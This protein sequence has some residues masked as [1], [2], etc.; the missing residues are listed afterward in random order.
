MT[1]S[2]AIDTST[3]GWAGLTAEL[4]HWH[5][6]GRTATLWW[7]DDDAVEDTLALRRLI[8]VA[9]APIA[10][11]VIPAALQD[12][13]APCL[14]ESGERGRIS[15]LQHGFAHRNHEPA[16]QKKA[17]LGAARPIATVL[18]ELTEG[19]RLLRRAFGGRSLPVLTPPW[20][21]ISA[22]LITHLP[23][24]GFRGLTTYLPRRS[25]WPANTLLQVN[26]HVD[27]I[28]WHGGRGFIG[29]EQ[30]LDLLTRHL[31]ARRKAVADSAEPTGILTHHLVQ[32]DAS[33]DF[34]DRLQDWLSAYPV[35]RWLT[36][37]EVFAVAMDRMGE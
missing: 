8:T 15:V 30:C 25:A 32:D 20:N 11:A 13:L 5:D 24:A 26:T 6:S 33:W 23:Q 31:Q 7:R 12:S 10:L 27:L 1:D 35:I 18:T 4:A 36:A 3:A 2:N 9:R 28:D 37:E 19:Q 16:S 34:L 14:A 17:E 22:A 21:R 29:V